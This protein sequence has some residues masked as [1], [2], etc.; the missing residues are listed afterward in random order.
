[1]TSQ[2]ALNNNL[3]K[4]LKESG[5]LVERGACV[6]E[7]PVSNTGL[8]C[9]DLS[10][11]IDGKLSPH[12]EQ[13]NRGIQDEQSRKTSEVGQESSEIVKQG[14]NI[15][16][17]FPLY[18]EQPNWS[19]QYN[20]YRFTSRVDW[21]QGTFRYDGLD[22]LPHIQ[23]R[24]GEIFNDNWEGNCGPFS[25]GMKFDDSARSVAKIMMAWQI[26]NPEK[27]Y[28]EFVGWL[29]IPG[30][31]I[32]RIMNKAGIE[33]L[34]LL[35]DFLETGLIPGSDRKFLRFWKCTRLDTTIDDFEKKIR[36]GDL[37]AI[38][39]KGNYAGFKH[40]GHFD[41]ITKKWIAPCIDYQ[42]STVCD[43]SGTV[44]WAGTIYFG[45]KQ[46]NKTLYIYDKF[47][48]SEGKLD[49]VR[50]EAR[51]KD[52]YAD[53]RFRR[54]LH[55]LR[56]DPGDIANIIASMTTGAIDF[57][58]RGHSTAKRAAARVAECPRYA[59]WQEFLDALGS[60]RIAIAAPEVTAEKVV[61][62]INYQVAVSLVA[63]S[64]I[65]GIDE[66]ISALE[67]IRD[68]AEKR[69]KKRHKAF[70]AQGKIDNFNIHECLN[71]IFAKFGGCTD[72]C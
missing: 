59:F 37:L 48:Q 41:K 12:E 15:V 23:M 71:R 54:I 29:C 8:S 36:P 1:M 10:T 21:I 30:S 65:C 9:R 39:E 49:S 63:L 62:W 40:N 26:P 3:L 72:I 68:N 13:P 4:T 47:L 33:N 20:P 22:A 58:D 61:G 51:W 25:S 50:W 2:D 6:K 27:E 66:L 34:L 42:Q 17:Q 57:I 46:G 44:L 45:S 24:L 53:V 19:A 28:E 55:H 7:T 60:I 43:S 52:E 5:H 70:I 64:K 16:K 69:L 56:E 67:R 35:F 38:A 11:K 14:P 18:D 32:D 31:A